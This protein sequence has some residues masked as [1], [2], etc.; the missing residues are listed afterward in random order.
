MRIATFR[1]EGILQK[2]QLLTTGAP[3][4]QKQQ[5]E[6]LREQVLPAIGNDSSLMRRAITSNSSASLII[7]PMTEGGRRSD[8]SVDDFRVRKMFALCLGGI[9]RK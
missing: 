2:L 1:L 7:W 9:H 3:A 8:G 6:V 4:R 5:Y